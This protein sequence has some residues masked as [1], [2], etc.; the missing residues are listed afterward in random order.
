ML[1]KFY[2]TV[3][4]RFEAGKVTHVET[5]TRRTWQYADL[6]EKHDPKAKV[7]S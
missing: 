7:S 5:Q 6:P 3:T 2:G 4:I 1:D